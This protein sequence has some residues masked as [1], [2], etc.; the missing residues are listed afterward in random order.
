MGS[1]R[2]RPITGRVVLIWLLA[3]FGLIFA[4]NG[5][6][7]YLA[8]NSFSG[9]TTEHSY[10]EGLAYNQKLAAEE[11]E[12]A[13]GWQAAVETTLAD[14][15][16]NVTI[17]IVLQ[18]RDGLPLRDLSVSGELRRPA[19]DRS[20][21]SL[22]FSAAGEGRYETDVV[23]AN[24]GNWDLHLTAQAADGRELRITRRLWLK[25]SP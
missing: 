10:R 6:F 3:F 8:L 20:D 14:V 18:D 5:V 16:G 15:D 2:G 25:S 21:R 22:A 7:V 1:H 11:A 9:L 17:S 12:R 24:M 13:L 23:L 4:I 19:E